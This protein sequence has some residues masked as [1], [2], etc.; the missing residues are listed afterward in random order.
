MPRSELKYG[1]YLSYISL[2]VTNI[3]NLILTPF[4]IKSLG[5]S[6]YGLYM[7]IGAFVGYI[8]VLDFGLGNTVV[9]FVAKYRAENDKK[10]EENFLFSTFLIY[11]IISV[12]V[13]LI[14]TIIY[15]NLS[16]IFGG[17]LTSNEIEQAKVMFV[18]LVINLALT[19]PMKSFTAIM[20][21]YERFILP[22]SL[23][24]F[25]I[26]LRMI[27]I[28]ILL[29]LGYKAVAIVVVDSALNL[30][31]LMINMLYVFFKLKVRIRLHYLDI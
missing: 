2:F 23:A 11:T 24:I 9:R 8:A 7:L 3:S 10:S 31:M 26:I 27:I 29:S 21:A 30:L 14:G 13:L 5:N 4:I 22:R 20:T 19:L 25:R 16:K 12:V 1:V 6:Q 17:S 18:I 15:F 28:F